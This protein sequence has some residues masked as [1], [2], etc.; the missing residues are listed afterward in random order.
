MLGGR[1]GAVGADRTHCLPLTMR[2]LFLTS[3]NGVKWHPETELNGRSH[4]SEGRSLVPQAG[5]KMTATTE[6]SKA[7]DRQYSRDHRAA[8]LENARARDRRRKRVGRGLSPDDGV[9]R[10]Q[11]RQKPPKPRR[12]SKGYLELAIAPN[13]VTVHQVVMENHLQRRLLPHESVHHKNLQRDDNRL[14]NLELWSKSQ[15]VGARVEDL[16]SWAR[17]I[18]RTY[19]NW[20]RRQE[21]NP[22]V[23]V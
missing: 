2:V 23:S 5:V 9:R 7:Y 19:E 1:D 8:N 10:M 3:Y 15:P 17:E 13:K 14:S 21:S 22:R 18:L 6:H 12:N 11:D 16:L 4:P 20:P